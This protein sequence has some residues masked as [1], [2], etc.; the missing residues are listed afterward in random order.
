MERIP[1]LCAASSNGGCVFW[2]LRASR[3]LLLS[4]SLHLSG[5]CLCSLSLSWTSVV[6]FTFYPEDN[7]GRLK[8]FN[9][10]VT[11]LHFLVLTITLNTV[12][13]L[14]EQLEGRW[15]EMPSSAV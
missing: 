2:L 9:W 5:H 4:L 11:H 10:E 12:V 7:G 8:T 3:L 1:P 13:E 6:I 14:E 15:G